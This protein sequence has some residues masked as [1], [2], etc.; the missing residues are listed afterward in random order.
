M[1]NLNP[2]WGFPALAKKAHYFPEGELICL[3]RR[4]MYAGEREDFTHDHQDNCS[5]CRRKLRALTEV[6]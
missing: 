3:C 5:E 6:K 4:W 2:G 1:D